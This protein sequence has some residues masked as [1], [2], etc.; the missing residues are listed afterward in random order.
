MRRRAEA[1]WP[2][3]I[4]TLKQASVL[5]G[6]QNKTEQ[7]YRLVR[8]LKKKFSETRV[9]GLEKEKTLIEKFDAT[10]TQLSGHRDEPS[11]VSRRDV[12]TGMPA[13]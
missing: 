12:L 8:A 11:R 3:V 6:Q 2:R 13:E 4:T 1:G 10:L 9:S 5:H 7:A